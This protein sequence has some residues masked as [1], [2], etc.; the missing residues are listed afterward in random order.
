MSEQQRSA[1]STLEQYTEELNF[2]D[3][4][5]LGWEH[6]AQP[7][8]RGF[9]RLTPLTAQALVREARI[10]TKQRVLDVATGPGYAAAA[11]SLRGAKVLGIDIAEAAVALAKSENPGLEVRLGDAESLELP[12]NS[13]DAVLMNF[14]LMHLGDPD[15]ALREAF[16]VLKPGGRAAFSAWAKGPEAVAFVFV[17]DAVRKH[18]EPDVKL[19]PGPDF[20]RFSDIGENLRSLQA[21]GFND[22]HSSIFEQFWRFTDPDEVFQTLIHGTVRTGALLRAQAPADLQKIRASIALEVAKYKVGPEYLLPMSAVLA[23]GKKP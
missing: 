23:V 10:E 20:F 22:V 1:G 14:V 17:R 6:A 21:A 9:S 16:R 4:E 3:F 19:P 18:G 5:K 2:R 11:A 8:H 13:F 12:E 7:Y 15:K